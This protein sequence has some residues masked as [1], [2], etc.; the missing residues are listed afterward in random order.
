M[1]ARSDCLGVPDFARRSVPV[2]GRSPTARSR[3]QRCQL[4][5]DAPALA[6]VCWDTAGWIEAAN[7]ERLSDDGDRLQYGFLNQR[8]SH[9]LRCELRELLD[10][11]WP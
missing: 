10:V 2:R 8:F 4:A 5:R 3:T 6:V 1:T 11:L 9:D 7:S